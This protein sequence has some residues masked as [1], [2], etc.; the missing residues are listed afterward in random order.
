M[1]VHPA[2][3][4]ASLDHTVTSFLRRLASLV[5]GDMGPHVVGGFLRDALLGRATR[6]LD[7]AVSGDALALARRLADA[8]G[9]AYV[10]LDD[11]RKI[12]RVVA[13]HENET[14]Q[15][16]VAA[17]QGD[18][19]QDLARRDFTINAMSVPLDGMLEEAWPSLI[20]DPL[21]GREDL[22]RRQVSAVSPDVFREDGIRLLRAVRLAAQLDFAIDPA[23]RELVQQDASAL[24]GVA[25]ERVKDELLAILASDSALQNVHLLDELG[26]LTRIFPEL[27][28]GRDVRQPREHHW[29]VLRHNMETVGAVEGLLTRELEPAWALEMVPWPADMDSYFKEMMTDGH[30]RGT[31]LKLAGLL[32]DVA[33]PATRTV[34]PEGRIRFLGHHTHG[35]DM[36]GKAL[37]RLR[38]SNKGI[39]LVRT[40]IEHHLRP[41]LMSHGDELATP[42]AVFRY[43]R[44]AGD[45]YLDTLYLNLADYLAAR[46]PYL[47]QDE[48]A[49]YT[50]KV[51][52]ILEYGAGQR[53]KAPAKPR[54]VDGNALMVALALP[55]GPL[56]GR[57]LDAIQEAQAT[58][59]VNTTDEAITLAGRM[60]ASQLTESDRA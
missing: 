18:R 2:T 59:E 4:V 13:H 11:P 55:P 6:D 32:H 29:D 51:R 10:P 53:E 16:D 12:A 27:E 50:N 31:L 21:D 60:I 43:F 5:P 14:W 47:E 26:L 46:G 44:S 40:Q 37:K 1:S 57:L 24:H 20:L 30:T 3:S 8:L 9:G 22:E 39:A 35:A 56:V 25:G 15:I 23:T 34:T 7:L 48:W 54:L 17:L 19:L 42:R 28:A 41:A 49:A 38:F 33:K 52:H 58:G 36:A 45:A